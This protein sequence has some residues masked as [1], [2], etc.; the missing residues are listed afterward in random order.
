M[1]DRFAESSSDTVSDI[2]ELHSIPPPCSLLCYSGCTFQPNA[3]P[4]DPMFGR[5][6]LGRRQSPWPA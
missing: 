4:R 1:S 2:L 3:S 6:V 5:W